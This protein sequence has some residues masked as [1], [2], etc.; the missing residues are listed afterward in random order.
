[1]I[2][3]SDA[4][5]TPANSRVAVGSV[6]QENPSRGRDMVRGVRLSTWSYIWHARPAVAFTYPFIYACAFPIFLLDA[7]MSLYQLVCFPIYGLPRVRRRD[8][9]LFDRALLT[10]LN[11]LERIN[12]LY[13]SYA[14]GVMAYAAEIAARTEQ[15]WC[16]IKH[17]KFPPSPHSRYGHFLPYGD[18]LAYRRWLDSVRIDYHDLEV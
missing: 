5:E 9:L 2:H 6:G 14:N 3:S 12:C 8:Y 17:S 1:M 13:C 16:P 18:E 10:Y 4:V 7:F 15:H 11:L